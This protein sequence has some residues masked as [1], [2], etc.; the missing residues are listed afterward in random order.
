M[1]F[2]SKKHKSHII[3]N[4]VMFVIGKNYLVILILIDYDD[5]NDL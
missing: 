1:N 4:Y 2:T 3:Y 5:Q